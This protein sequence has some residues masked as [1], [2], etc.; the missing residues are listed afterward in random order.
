MNLGEFLD[1][2]SI[3]LHKAE[4]IGPDSYKEFIFYAQELLLEVE[5]NDFNKLIKTFRELY[6][7]NGQIWKLES[8]IR[9]K[10]EKQ[11]GIEEVGKRAI[12]IRNFNN[13][14]ITIQNEFIEEFGGHKN[15][16]VN[17]WKKLK[18]ITKKEK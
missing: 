17:Y 16:N 13:K 12:A 14:R 2:L 8:D 10:K 9:L 4:K 7:V 18:K 3:H 15:P 11:L 1:R 5:V 6:K